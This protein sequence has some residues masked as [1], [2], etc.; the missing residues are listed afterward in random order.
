MGLERLQ[1]IFNNIEDNV[2]SLEDGYPVES[3]SNSLYDDFHSFGTQGNRSE[4]I[5]ITKIDKKQNPS[6]LVAIN[7]IF[8]ED[9]TITPINPINGHNFRQI[10]I[11]DNAG[12][13]LL[14]T[15]G[16]EYSGD[17]GYG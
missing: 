3:V 13:N 1:S 10:R 9:G 7:G 11:N 5:Q 2:Q 15:V 17:A 8:A 14:Q 16:T 4:L 12:T 6:P